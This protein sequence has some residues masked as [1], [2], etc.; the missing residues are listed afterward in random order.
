MVGP[1][2]S[3]NAPSSE[4][5]LTRSQLPLTWTIVHPIDAS[6]PLFGQSAEDLRA[7]E[8]EF[9]VLLSALDET[10]GATVQSR[11][12]YRGDELQWFQVAE[13]SF[14]SFMLRHQSG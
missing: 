8:A 7:S 14:D 13:Q 6:S 11:S 4:S 10:T 1:P 2:L 3:C 9:M 12:S 5:E